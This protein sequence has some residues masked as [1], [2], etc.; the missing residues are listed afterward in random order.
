M[1]SKAKIGS[2][3]LVNPV[4]DPLDWVK[5]LLVWLLLLGS[6]V[7]NYYYSQD[8]LPAV[9]RTMAWMAI[10]AVAA[11]LASR[12]D[13]GRRF[14]RFANDARIELRK[15]IWPKREE[16]LQTTLAVAAMVL[17]LSLVLWGIDGLLVWLVS[18]ITS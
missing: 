10:M 17:V 3:K 2:M 4:K 13:K 8:G 11:Y 14:V 5:W 16:V 15:V 7:G 6:L 1:N 9:V 12:T 18:K